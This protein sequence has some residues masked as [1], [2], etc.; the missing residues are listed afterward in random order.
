MILFFFVTVFKFVHY[1]FKFLSSE[2]D[3]GSDYTP[4]EI[5]AATRMSSVLFAKS[6][7]SVKSAV[8]CFYS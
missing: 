3:A 6:E 1:L 2:K 5:T 7:D 4:L 8:L